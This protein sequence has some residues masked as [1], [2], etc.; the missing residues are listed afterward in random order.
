MEKVRWTLGHLPNLRKFPCSEVLCKQHTIPSPA[1]YPSE[2]LIWLWEMQ[3][4]KETTGP[5]SKN[6]ACYLLAKL[7]VLCLRS[8]VLEAVDTCK[9]G[10]ILL[11]L[12]RITMA[13]M[14]NIPVRQNCCSFKT[15]IWKQG[16]SDHQT[17]WDTYFN[18]HGKASR[19]LQDSKI[20]SLKDV[21]Q[22]ANEKWMRDT[23][24]KDFT[25]GMTPAILSSLLCLSTSSINLLS[26]LP[27]YSEKNYK[28]INKSQNFPQQLECPISTFKGQSRD[29]LLSRLRRSEGFSGKWL[30]VPP[31]NRW[32]PGKTGRDW[33]RLRILTRV[34]ALDLRSTWLRKEGKT[35][36]CSCFSKSRLRQIWFL[37]AHLLSVLSLPEVVIDFLFV[38]FCVLRTWV[39]FLPAYGIQLSVL[40]YAGSSA[41]RLGHKRYGWAEMW[42]A[43]QLW[44]GF[45]CCLSQNGCLSFDCLWEWL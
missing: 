9:N 34:S 5:M 10:K 16:L 33:W 1:A 32:D 24:T 13:I 28:T 6:W 7:L 43:F 22:K 44:L 23:K 25:T 11:R 17:E 40:A 8:A 26:K 27:F 2:E 37:G 39:G 38:L 18:W 35:S 31:L 20:A 3:T 15:C 30:P 42:A 45:Y 36:C 41:I 29:G 4:T 21:L 19:R 14:E 12:P